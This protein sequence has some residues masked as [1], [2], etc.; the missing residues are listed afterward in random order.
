MV[1]VVHLNISNLP[2]T[3]A[4]LTDQAGKSGGLGVGYYQVQKYTSGVYPQTSL[5]EG[6]TALYLFWGVVDANTYDTYA[7]NATQ[8]Y[9]DFSYPAA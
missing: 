3:S 5:G 9:F 2:F 4:N 7:N 6:S 1:L 8:L